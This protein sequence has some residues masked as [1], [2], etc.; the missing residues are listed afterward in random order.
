MFRKKNLTIKL[1]IGRSFQI[2]QL[3]ADI[4]YQCLAKRNVTKTKDIIFVKRKSIR[5]LENSSENV[6]LVAS[7]NQLRH[8]LE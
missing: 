6:M 8:I 5:F 3:I 1:K 2:I 7:S 4:Q